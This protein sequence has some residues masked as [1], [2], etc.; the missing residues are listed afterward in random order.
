MS[1]TFFAKFS[2]EASN[3][4]TLAI[5]ALAVTVAVG[6]FAFVVSEAAIFS[7]PAWVALAFAVYVVASLAA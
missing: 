5:G 2:F 4:N 3:A 7:F 1:L 6:D